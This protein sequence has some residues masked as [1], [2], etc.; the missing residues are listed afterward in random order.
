MVKTPYF[1]GRLPRA[2]SLIELLAAMT[3]LT[4]VAALLIPTYQG[5]RDQAEKVRCLSNLRILHN[6]LLGF[7]AD[8]GFFP[9]GY[10]EGSPPSD[11][12]S[13]FPGKWSVTRLRFDETWKKDIPGAVGVHSNWQIELAPYV[14]E[15][16]VQFFL[17]NPED[18]NF[19]GPLYGASYA[20]HKYANP[21]TALGREYDWRL[22]LEFR[23]PG[24]TRKLRDPANDHDGG[25]H[26]F[27]HKLD[28]YGYCYNQWLT[29]GSGTHD[30]TYSLGEFCHKGRDPRLIDP[31]YAP[32][33]S[34]SNLL[35]LFCSRWGVVYPKSDFPGDD[36][37]G[38]AP[39]IPGA[40]PYFKGFPDPAPTGKSSVGSGTF[41]GV[42]AG[43][44][45]TRDNCLFMDGH[46]ETLNPDDPADRRRMNKSWYRPLPLNVSC[47][48]YY[49]DGVRA[50]VAIHF[51]SDGFGAGA[52]WS[53]GTWSGIPAPANYNWDQ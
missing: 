53:D 22:P 17:Y 50:Q 10:T 51:D 45:G 40:T 4:V 25:N 11:S 39:M 5:V 49:S 34:S 33:A 31:G 44:H 52:L 2:F 9:I 38:R 12:L 1:T 14:G 23:C 20:T 46:A 19:Y 26:G 13:N 27:A 30:R 42:A 16:L 41:C 6:A 3:I 21:R 37:T 32:A 48:N 7:Q 36:I 29:M 18:P 15:G 28:H 43:I 8:H 47:G 35:I 24:Y